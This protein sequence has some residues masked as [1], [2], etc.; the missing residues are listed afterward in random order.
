MPPTDV[1]LENEEELQDGEEAPAGGSKIV[2]WLVILGLAILFLP[3]YVIAT[4][5]K[6][7]NE[8]LTSDIE[9]IQATLTAPPPVNPVYET[10]SAQY[11]DV[12]NQSKT[13]GSIQSTLLAGHINWPTI[14]AMIG[15]YDTNQMKVNTVS[16]I[17]T[18]L[19]ITGRAQQEIVAMSYAD[20]LRNSGLFDLVAV[21]SITLQSIM[22]T[23]T[24]ENTTAA[25]TAITQATLV[26][27]QQITPTPVPT[28]E[29]KVTD[30]IISV[31]IKKETAT[32]GRST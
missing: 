3:L 17:E 19:R 29:I 28:M 32:D 15:A 12:Q 2:I 25:P 31:T 6:T 1:D 5:V 21:E 27:N 24:P 30:F 10:L 18:G 16:Q 13:L 11:L 4:T 23:V 26:P 14:M 22:I 7:T 20:M 8:K 9:H